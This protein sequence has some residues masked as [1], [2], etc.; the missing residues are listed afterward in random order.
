MGTVNF[1]EYLLL[2][3]HISIFTSLDSYN[4]TESISVVS[5][6]Q[7]TYVFAKI[8]HKVSESFMLNMGCIENLALR[9]EISWCGNIQNV[10]DFDTELAGC[11]GNIS[12]AILLYIQ[13]SFGIESK[14]RS[15]IIHD[16]KCALPVS[17]SLRSTFDRL[18][19]QLCSSYMVVFNVRGKH[20]R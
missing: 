2:I 4:S 11:N 13:L 1:K 20:S 7:F 3:F 10:H 16:N 8:E 15:C 14:N 9:R 17:P 12:H 6:Q 18:H 5:I 19:L